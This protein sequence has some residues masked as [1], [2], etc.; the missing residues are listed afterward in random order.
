MLDKG[1][2]EEEAAVA[3]EAPAGTGI[4]VGVGGGGSN[5]KV[6]GVRVRVCA[7]EVL[8]PGLTPLVAILPIRGDVLGCDADTDDSAAAAVAAR[9]LRSSL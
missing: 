2:P 4:G 3:A 1:P 8:L 6:S 7:D 5:I 9:S